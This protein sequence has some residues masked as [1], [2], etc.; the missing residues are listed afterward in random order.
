VNNSLA[1]VRVAGLGFWAQILRGFLRAVISGTRSPA[2]L[3]GRADPAIGQ[4]ARAPVML[5][6]ARTCPSTDA[7]SS[8]WDDVADGSSRVATT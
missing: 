2:A 5:P 1:R 3:P 6:D 8:C 4:V 7:R